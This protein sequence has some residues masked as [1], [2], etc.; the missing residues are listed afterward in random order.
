MGEHMGVIVALPLNGSPI[1]TL[2]QYR[3]GQ[4]MERALSL[5]QVDVF[6]TSSCFSVLY[7]RH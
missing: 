1:Y 7:R 3:W 4:V 2:I 6:S 5:R